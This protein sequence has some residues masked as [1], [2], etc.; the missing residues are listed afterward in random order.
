MAVDIE[1]APLDVNEGRDNTH[2]PPL[3]DGSAPN[4]P[5]LQIAPLASG[6]DLNG[7]DELRLVTAEDVQDMSYE[8]YRNILDPLHT[9]YCT[10]IRELIETH[11]AQWGRQY[12]E[13]QQR[14]HRIA[15]SWRR[16]EQEKVRELERLLNEI[17]EVRAIVQSAVRV[18]AN[19]IVRHFHDRKRELRR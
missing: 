3:T 12:G 14:A 19:Q 15:F 6:E 16:T 1:S 4:P 2:N 11:E 7:E 10:M 8:D 18:H 5:P 17:K 13:Y 9:D